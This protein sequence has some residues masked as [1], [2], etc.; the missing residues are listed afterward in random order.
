MRRGWIGAV[1]VAIAVVGLAPVSSANAAR[2]TSNQFTVAVY[3]D[4]PY[5]SS[6]T[7]QREPRRAR[8]RHP[9]RQGVLHPGVRQQD[10]DAVAALREAARVHAGRQRM[11]RLPQA[12]SGWRQVD[13]P[14][15][16]VPNFHRVMVHG[17]SSLEWLKLTIDPNA[18][19]A[20]APT[21]SARSPGSESPTRG[22]PES[23]RRTLF[24]IDAEHATL[25]LPIRAGGAAL[26]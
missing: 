10:Q 21:R 14:S 2:G 11:E 1:V 5:G 22:N 16:D 26:T 25:P 4:A 20:R 3:G 7:S 12:R 9:L 8:G 18:T 17:S 19:S 15:Y 6:R 24:A 13:H 23:H